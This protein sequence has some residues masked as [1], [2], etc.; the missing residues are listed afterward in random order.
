MTKEIKILTKVDCYG[1]EI[2]YE[3]PDK[4]KKYLNTYESTYPIIFPVF[5]RISVMRYESNQ[6]ICFKCRKSFHNYLYACPVEGHS[7]NA[8][9]SLEKCN[10]CS[11]KLVMSQTLSFKTPKKSNTKAWESLKE[12]FETMLKKE[13]HFCCKQFYY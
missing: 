11:E 5:K 1:D 2:T 6:G 3:I 8:K 13:E 12:Q 9:R 4:I 10:I 7:G